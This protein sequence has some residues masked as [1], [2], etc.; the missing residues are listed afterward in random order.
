MDSQGFEFLSVAPGRVFD[1]LGVG[2]TQK[3]AGNGHGV[4][5]LFIF[6]EE[7]GQIALA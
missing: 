6:F 4:A 7:E 1:G 2:I 3:A 5:L